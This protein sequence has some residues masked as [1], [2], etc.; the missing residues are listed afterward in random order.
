MKKIAI[1]II[2]VAIMFQSTFCI[3]KHLQTS[4]EEVYQTSSI[5]QAAEKKSTNKS[6]SDEMKEAQQLKIVTKDM[7]KRLSKKAS[8]YDVVFMI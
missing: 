5:V 4:A 7:R 8:Q 6:T 1:H 2:I 3:P